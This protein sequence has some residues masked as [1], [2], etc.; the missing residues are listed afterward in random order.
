[1]HHHPHDGPAE[2]DLRDDPYSVWADSPLRVPAPCIPPARR[3]GL[4]LQDEHD[5]VILN[6]VIFLGISIGGLDSEG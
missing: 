3:T 2:F 5:G 1:M 6:A 4:A